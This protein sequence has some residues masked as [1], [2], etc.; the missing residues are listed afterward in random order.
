MW[1]MVE[2]NLFILHL[3]HEGYYCCALVRC[4]GYSLPNISETYMLLQPFPELIKQNSQQKSNKINSSSSCGI[5]LIFLPRS[6]LWRLCPSIRSR[7]SLLQPF[8]W[9]L[10]AGAC[11]TVTM[12]TC[13]NKKITTVQ[14]YKSF[15]QSQL[16]SRVE[17]AHNKVLLCWYDC[18]RH[19]HLI[20]TMMEKELDPEGFFL[21]LNNSATTAEKN[22]KTLVVKT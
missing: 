18:N 14:Y 21:L 13:F 8:G 9:P 19:W 15:N 16:E 20:V 6:Y 3:W 2:G 7:C 1:A 10:C 17:H 5:W 12:D 11:D 22:K 4:H